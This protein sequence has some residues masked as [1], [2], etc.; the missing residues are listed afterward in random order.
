M[1]TDG[2]KS[3]GLGFRAGYRRRMSKDFM[4]NAIFILVA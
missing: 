4:Q 2:M 1:F 3:M